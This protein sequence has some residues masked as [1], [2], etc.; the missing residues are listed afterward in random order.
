MSADTVPSSGAM[1]VSDSY[2]VA[3]PARVR[4]LSRPTVCQLQFAQY[5][6]A[7]PKGK[8]Q[9]TLWLR[10]Q[11][12]PQAKKLACRSSE[13]VCSGCTNADI[14]AEHIRGD[15]V[16][17]TQRPNSCVRCLSLKNNRRRRVSGLEVG[18]LQPEQHPFEVTGC[19]EKDRQHGGRA[20]AL[21][22]DGIDSVPL[23][24]CGII[25]L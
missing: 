3:E 10:E 8:S 7:K 4:R 21:R 23:L 15:A 2:P 9:F 1:T 24:T 25:S 6:V 16:E 20:A 22:V 11:V 17:A 13:V 12:D 5:H 14:L 18:K 19:L